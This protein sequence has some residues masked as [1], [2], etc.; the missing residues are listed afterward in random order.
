MKWNLFAGVMLALVTT[1]ASHAGIV[2][3]WS[4]GMDGSQEVPPVS[5]DAAGYASGTFDP[6]TNKLVV[7]SMLAAQFSSN[8]TMSHI[9]RGPAGANGPVIIN[10]PSFGTWT[11]NP[12]LYTYTQTADIVI[13]AGEVAGLLAGNTY[14]NLHSANFPGGEVRGQILFGGARSVP[15]RYAVTRGV[16]IGGNE[17]SRLWEDDDR[18][19]VVQQRF[20]PSPTLPNAELVATFSAAT[21]FDPTAGQLLVR[22]KAN[23]LPLDDR[24]CR[25]QIAI[26]N[27]SGQFVVVDERKPEN[28][29]SGEAEV[30]VDLDEAQL[31][32]FIVNEQVEVAVRVFHLNPAL[33]AWTM[34]IDQMQLTLLR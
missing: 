11:G 16:L 23:S 27:A 17:V 21:R 13:P 2:L 33:P 28:P 12:Q 25:Q 10:F 20:Q 29:S 3:L 7:E 30:F 24:T 4:A 32:S 31:R 14:I 9:H 26:R 1:A 34:T 22:V 15:D 18:S 8:L 6:A 5:T 19:L